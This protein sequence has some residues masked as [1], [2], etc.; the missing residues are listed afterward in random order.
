VRELKSAVAHA[1]ALAAGAPQ[2]ERS[3]LPRI[4]VPSGGSRVGATGDAKTRQQIVRD[5]VSDTVSACAGNL[6][7]AARRLGV[8]RSTLYR[9]LKTR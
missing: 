2:I 7:E 3:H 1:L 4:L 5:A 9:S 6:S 8:A